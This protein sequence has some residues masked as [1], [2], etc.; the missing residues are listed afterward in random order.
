M[1]FSTPATAI[2]FLQAIENA[3]SIKEISWENCG[4]LGVDNTTVNIGRYN[5]LID[6]LERKTRISNSWVAL[7]THLTLLKNFARYC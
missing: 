5:S 3:K 7:A 1:C 6:N 4:T 2:G